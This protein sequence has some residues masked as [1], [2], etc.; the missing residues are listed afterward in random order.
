MFIA[1]DISKNAIARGDIGI[2]LAPTAVFNAFCSKVIWT[3]SPCNLNWPDRFKSM[4]IK[5]KAT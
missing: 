4:P 5:I 2:E 1:I 3:T